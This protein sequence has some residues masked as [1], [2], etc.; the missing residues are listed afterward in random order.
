MPN[1]IDHTNR[2]SQAWKTSIILFVCRSGRFLDANTSDY[3]RVFA[4][5]WMRRA[6]SHFFFS[7][8]LRREEEMKKEREREK[9]KTFPLWKWFARQEG[10]EVCCIVS[11]WNSRHTRRL[12]LYFI[13]LPNIG[14]VVSREVRD[15]HCWIKSHYTLMCAYVRSNNQII[16]LRCGKNGNGLKSLALVCTCVCDVS[17][18]SQTGKKKK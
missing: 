7:L 2:P 6:D 10:L 16:S 8:F 11:V 14:F 5:V 12:H 18:K 13:I 3:Q 4:S 15:E 17:K 1:K 9:A